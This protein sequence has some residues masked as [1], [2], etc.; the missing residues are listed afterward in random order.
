MIDV[1]KLVIDL[2][3]YIEKNHCSHEETHRGGAIWTICE[4]CGAKWADDQGGMP[5]DAGEEPEVVTR[6][7]KYLDE[8]AKSPKPGKHVLTPQT[9]KMILWAAYDSMGN[10]ILIF[11]APESYTRNDA[12][13]AC[14]PYIPANKNMVTVSTIPHV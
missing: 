12:Y 3:H 4:R 9:S 10:Q 7:Y 14:K 5:E 6:A 13:D 11:Y 1:E 8:L 2:A